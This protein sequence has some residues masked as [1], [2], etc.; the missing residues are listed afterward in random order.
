MGVD[1]MLE[2]VDLV[3]LAR[4]RASSRTRRRPPMKAAAVPTMPISTGA[5]RGS[6]IDRLI[7]G[8]NPAPGAWST[9]DGKTL[10]IFEAKPLPAKDPQGHRRQDG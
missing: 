6:D 4:R 1:A 7:R 3:K 2:A 5:G 10:K 8:C 9:L